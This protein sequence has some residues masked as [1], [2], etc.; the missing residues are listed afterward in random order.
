MQGR[1]ERLGSHLLIDDVESG[2]VDQTDIK[3]LLADLQDSIVT[4]VEHLSERNDVS[5]FTLEDSL[6]LSRFELV[7]A[8][9]E[10]RPIRFQD[11]RNLGT[12]REDEADATLEE[13]SLDDC[14]HLGS[15]G[16]E[17]QP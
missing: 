4:P 13:D 11:V 17:V 7:V 16:W 6:I 12:S 9:E 8:L 15:V 5:S 10:S 1:L 2:L 14:D 3:T